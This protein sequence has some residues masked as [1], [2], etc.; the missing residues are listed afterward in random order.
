MLTDPAVAD[1]LQKCGC[2]DLLRRVAVDCHRKLRPGYA[3]EF[4]CYL[5]WTDNSVVGSP[6]ANRPST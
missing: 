4:R 2:G 1:I 3:R 6:C 5:G